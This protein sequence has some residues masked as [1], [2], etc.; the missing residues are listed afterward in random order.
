MTSRSPRQPSPGRR[1]PLSR[2][3]ARPSGTPVTRR[4]AR[5]A[6]CAVTALLWLSSSAAP[7]PAYAT[8]LSESRARVLTLVNDHRAVAGC[9]AVRPSPALRRAAQ[10]HSAEMSRRG[11]FSHRGARGSGPSDRARAAGYRPSRL[12]ENIAVGQRTAAQV[13]TAWMRSPPHRR[14]LLNCAYL[15]IGL[16]VVPSPD[17]PWWTLMLGTTHSGPAWSRST[18]RPS[19]SS[20]HVSDPSV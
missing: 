15:D 11:V 13:V 8:D 10:R 7:A 2:R 9:R 20:P 12:A 14:A 6:V 19:P 17:G 16:G 18:A 3:R 1:P 4:P 5:A